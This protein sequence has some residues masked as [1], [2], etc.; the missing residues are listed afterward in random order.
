ML[1]RLKESVFFGGSL[2]LPFAN[3]VNCI[4]FHWVV[5]LNPF[6][7]YFDAHYLFQR[8][9]LQGLFQYY[10]LQI[11]PSASRQVCRFVRK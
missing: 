1:C 11:V 8:F 7:T 3:S 6:H 10:D 5:Y 4:Y 2:Y 9:D